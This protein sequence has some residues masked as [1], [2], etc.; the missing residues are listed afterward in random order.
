MKIALVN[1]THFG[2]R[3]DSILVNEYF[4]KFWE[5][6][7]FPYLKEHDIK[8]VVHLG[9][10]VDRRKFINFKI[11]DDFRLRWLS[12]F[13]SEDIDLHLLVGNHDTYYKNT[14]RVNSLQNLCNVGQIYVDPAEVRFDGVDVLLLPW[15]CADNYNESVNMIKS[16]KAEI[17]FGHLEISGFE[18]DKGNVCHEGMDRAMFERF[19]M[20][21]SG[22]FHHKSTDGLIYYLGNQYEITW[23]DYNDNRG[24]HVFDT[25]TR[26]LTFVPNP[27]KLFFKFVYDDKDDLTF[28][29]LE[30]I[31]FDQY[32][33]TYVKVLVVNKTNPY[34]FDKFM[35]EMNRCSP[36]DINVIED[37]IDLTDMQD[38]DTIEQAEDTVT[39]LNKYVDGLTLN[40]DNERL[41]GILREIYV[42]ALNTEV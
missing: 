36:I 12:R 1:D 6:I 14:N 39:I 30:E 19:D 38:D 11:A 10:V 37:T 23:A 27:Y 3:N 29:K 34:L 21:L 32:A 13:E 2:A 40:T 41:K 20:V 22:H 28:E 9:D 17:V 18:M 4:F 24:F 25:D 42:E 33:G 31:N 26:E 8:T 7:F 35:E 15:I 5:Q 16:T